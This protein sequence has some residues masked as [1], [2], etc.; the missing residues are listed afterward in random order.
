MTSNKSALVTAKFVSVGIAAILLGLATGCGK[1]PESETAA[2][3]AESI[4]AAP[5]SAPETT[6]PAIVAAALPA[7]PQAEVIDET[8]TNYVVDLEG[9]ETP[10]VEGMIYEIARTEQSPR[11]KAEALFAMFPRLEPGDQRKVALVALR[12][13]GDADYEVAAPH[14]MNST[15]DPQVLSVFMADALKRKNTLK[16][17]A[18]LELT[19]AEEHPLHAQARQLLGTYLGNDYGTNW[20]RWENRLAWWLSKNPS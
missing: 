9:G 16:M 4:A 8:G 18:L 19:R 13:I 11:E 20:T 12:Q 7:A 14:L 3:P 6:P 1:A 2:P 15:L 10:V 5:E 17:P